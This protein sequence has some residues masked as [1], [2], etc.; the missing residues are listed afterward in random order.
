M[1]M[2]RKRSL[3]SY[4]ELTKEQQRL[5]AEHLWISGSVAHRVKS[6][7]WGHTGA[8]TKD[9]LVQVAN[10]ALCV[11]AVQ[12]DGSRGVK[13]STYAYNK[14]QGYLNHALRDKSRMVRT[15][16]WIEKIRNPVLDGVKA[17]KT[18]AEIAEELGVEEGKVAICHLA[19]NNYHVSY[20][21][22]P[23]DWTS[24]EF[25]HLDD[26]VK[27]SLNC[28]HLLSEL[29]KLTEGDVNIILSYLDGGAGLSEQQKEWAADKFFE[30][31]GIAYGDS[32]YPYG[33]GITDANPAG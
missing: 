27:A 30:L 15:P 4:P 10:F 19:E 23:E 18:Y 12:Y 1:I 29:K 25:I 26:E 31:K 2:A 7:T 20:D 21:S 33:D 24:P 22:S 8:L 3:K 6:R 13:F 5:V 11:A 16:R 17:G 28:P 14:A 9:D 32:P